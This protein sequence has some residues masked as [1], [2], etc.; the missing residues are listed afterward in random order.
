MNIAKNYIAKVIKEIDEFSPHFFLRKDFINYQLKFFGEQIIYLGV[1]SE[2]DQSLYAYCSFVSREGHWINPITGGFGGIVSKKNTSIAA[3]ETLIKNI[4]NLILSKSP[5]KSI[6]FKIPPTCFSSEVAII[7]NILFRNNW[8]H[9]CFD[10]NYH[11]EI[12]PPDKYFKTLSKTNKKF[13]NKLEILGAKFMKSDL[14]EIANIYDI[15]KENRTSKGFP[16]TMT[17]EA[18]SELV[19]KFQS[20]IRL[21]SVS[22]NKETVASSVCIQVS[23]KYLYVFYWGQ[24]PKYNKISPILFL[25]KGIVKYCYENGIKI[26][27][28]GTSS[29]NSKPNIGLC[30][31]K[32]RLGCKI[33]QKSIYQ[34]KKN[35]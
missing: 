28:L 3:L 20:D 11:L 5:V 10:L 33:T 18:L 17:F 23:S 12:L 2:S 22:V 34:W 35:S 14:S 16:T 25:A 24:L 29:A 4:P 6:S 32:K 27:D 19:E 1:Y 26:M 31:F 21:F 9:T 13:I 7:L 30:D 15:I 8:I